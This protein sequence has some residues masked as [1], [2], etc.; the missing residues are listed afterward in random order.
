LPF[1]I[2]TTQIEPGLPGPAP[3]RREAY[4]IVEAESFAGLLAERYELK[5]LG[6]GCREGYETVYSILMRFRCAHSGHRDNRPERTRGSLADRHSLPGR[7]RNLS[8][9]GTADEGA[10]LALGDE[11]SRYFLGGR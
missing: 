9:V 6:N 5:K 11:C 10:P 4:V 2:I 1:G 8:F 3:L 7:R